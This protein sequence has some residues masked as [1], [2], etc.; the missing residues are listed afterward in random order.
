VCLASADAP[1]LPL[2]LRANVAYGDPAA[3]D[4]EIV[5]ALTAA[6]A[7]EL[8][9]E[10]PEGLDTLLGERGQRLSGGQRQR[11]ALARALLLRPRVLIL[12]DPVASVDA[13]TERLIA[14]RI[15]PIVRRQ[16]TLIVAHRPA[17]LELADRV[18]ALDGG[19]VRDR[20]A[21]PKRRSSAGAFGAHGRSTVDA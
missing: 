10:L 21:E 13:R 14:E 12:D 15:A 9:E 7:E 17:L 18:V 4:S 5:A 8:L 6:G 11:V 20:R 19:K 2:T 16:T 1:L 3:S